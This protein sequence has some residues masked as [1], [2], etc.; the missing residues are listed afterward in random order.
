MQNKYHIAFYCKEII[1]DTNITLPSDI[2]I[3]PKTLE[4]IKH[5]IKEQLNIEEDVVIL[6]WQKFDVAF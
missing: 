1:G 3:T 5:I 4:D 6:N 2:I